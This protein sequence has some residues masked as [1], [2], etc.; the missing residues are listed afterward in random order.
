M[1]NVA[2]WQEAVP[3]SLHVRIRDYVEQI[4]SYSDSH[5][6][7][8]IR[9]FVYDIIHRGISLLSEFQNN[10]QTS[11]MRRANW[12]LSPVLFSMAQAVVA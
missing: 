5:N 9:Y 6:L 2:S 1:N 7:E 11:L 4:N 10:V 12:R 8:L 3:N